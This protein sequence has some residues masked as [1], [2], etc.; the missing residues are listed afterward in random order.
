MA[1]L[2]CKPERKSCEPHGSWAV[3]RDNAME[4]KGQLPLWD[5]DKPQLERGDSV[6]AQAG[7]SPDMNI[8]SCRCW[9]RNPLLS[10]CPCTQLPFDWHPK[11]GSKGRYWQYLWLQGVGA[12]LSSTGTRCLGCLV[13]ALQWHGHTSPPS[14]GQLSSP[15]CPRQ[16]PPAS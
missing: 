13:L 4:G 3:G 1:E 5:K 6:S 15:G 2:G 11:G 14:L 8:G 16:P 7:K 12:L 9:G 10:L